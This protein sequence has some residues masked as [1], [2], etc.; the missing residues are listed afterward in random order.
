MF[1]ILTTNIYSKLLAVSDTPEVREYWKQINNKMAFTDPNAIYSEKYNSFT[2][3]GKRRWD[4]KV[5][6]FNIKT[7]AFFTGHLPFIIDILKSFNV[8]Y[9]VINKEL[10]PDCVIKKVSK[11]GKFTLRDYQLEGVQRAIDMHRGIFYHSTGAGKTIMALGICE[12]IPVT[13]LFLVD[14]HELLKQAYKV[15]SKNSSR[16]VGIIA[17]GEFEPRDI[18]IGMQKTI[19]SRMN[20]QYTKEEFINYLNTVQMIHVDECHKASSKTWKAVLRNLPSAY[21]R[22]GFSGTPL[23]EDTIRNMYTLGYI[24]RII[25]KKTTDTLVEDNYLAKPNINI[26]PLSN[27]N[28]SSLYDY[29]QIYKDG[30]TNNKERNTIIVDTVRQHKG[31]SI[32]IIVKHLEHGKILR[33]MLT[34][35]TSYFFVSGESSKSERMYVY[36]KFS[37]KDLPIVIASLIYKEGI[38]IPAIDVL[39]YAAGEKAPVTILQVLGRGLRKRD[40]KTI[41]EYYDFNDVSNFHLIRHTKQRLKIYKDQGFNIN[42]LR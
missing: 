12:S 38:D 15:F 36:D 2:A 32:L 14:R 5:Y 42:K 27:I 8:D 3:E 21:F 30:I 31:K 39:I 29:D 22:F 4:G 10:I 11:I 40:D 24:G 16:E 17:S 9:E 13:T 18:T 20:N 1:K 6:F 23:I 19:Y 37:S 35:D 26:L 34:E 33:K 7:G 41:L 28:I 25:H